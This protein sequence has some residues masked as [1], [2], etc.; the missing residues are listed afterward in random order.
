MPLIIGIDLGTTKTTSIA[1]DAGT[2]RTVAA[3]ASES[4]GRIETP[5]YPGRSEWN[6][7]LIIRCGLRCLKDLSEKL[8]EQSRGVA[9][10]G[11]TG[12]QHGT[13]IVDRQRI[14]LTP[15]I[16]WQDQRG[17]E[18]AEE[19][20]TWA[21]LGRERLGDSIV[22]R[23]GCRLNSGFLATTVFWLARNNC[24]PSGGTACFIAD[25]FAA[26]L[27]DT[28]P[29]CEPTNAGGA[30]VFDVTQR[31]WCSDAIDALELRASLFPQ[32]VEADQQVGQLTSSI[33][34]ETGLPAGLPVFPAIGDHQASFLGCVADRHSSILVNVGTGAQV[35]VFTPGTDFAQ[36]IELR[37]FP[38]EGNLLSNVGLPGG[39]QY[40]V[41]ETLIRKIGEDVF[42]I[43]TPAP[44]Y[45]QITKLA[46]AARPGAGGLSFTPT[47]SGTRSDPGQTGSLA[48]M[49]PV[50]LTP[51]NLIRS[52]L[53]GMAQ[54]YRDAYDQIARVTNGH[55]ARLIGAGNG[56][57]E[58]AILREIVSKSFDRQ[59]AVTRHREEAAFGAALI[60]AVGCGVLKNLDEAARL[61]H[62]VE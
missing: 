32:V 7:D 36:P 13:V 19:G 28:V 24:L 16:N 56:L 3:A 51:G 35:A 22:R 45:Q 47:F 25:L 30:G 62:Y 14:A 1:V 53:E 34:E 37:P 21:Q 17:N 46:S 61:F 41:V 20:K 31:A 15:F 50:N 18:P 39:W 44:L 4:G 12:Q 49:T 9:G 29:V 40:Q 43:E 5:G 33:A 58:N 57:R 59:L 11:I 55:P 26:S 2:G 8:G 42:G 6:S 38:Y 27:T 52:A 23:T 60:G 54:A 10:V 48:G